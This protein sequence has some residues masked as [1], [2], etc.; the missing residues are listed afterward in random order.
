MISKLS[1]LMLCS[2]SALASNQIAPVKPVADVSAI[3]DQFVSRLRD[4]FALKMNL[5][6]ESFD[7]RAENLVLY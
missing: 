6:V 5:P 3:G 4:S 1:I 7:V 2:V